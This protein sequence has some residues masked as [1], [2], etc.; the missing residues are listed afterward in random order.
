MRLFNAVRLPAP[1]YYRSL[2]ALGVPAVNRRLR[3]AGLV[4]CYHNVVAVR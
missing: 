3:D 1:I 2:R 4:L